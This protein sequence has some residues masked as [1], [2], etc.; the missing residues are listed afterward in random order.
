MDNPYRQK[1]LKAI[2]KLGQ[3]HSVWDVFS[4]FVEL[5]ALCI[6]NSIEVKGSETW[7]KRE[8][9]YLDTIGKYK[10]DEQ[11]LFPEMFADLVQAL[12]YE[13]TWRNAPTDVLGTL[14]HELELHNK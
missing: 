7:E 3:V 8:K 5:G 2:Q 12:D 13:L 4:D 10:P 1:V 9:Q 6:A 14:F 11:K